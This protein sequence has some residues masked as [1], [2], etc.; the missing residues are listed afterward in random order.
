MSSRREAI[1]ELAL[2]PGPKRC[3]PNPNMRTGL[4]APLLQRDGGSAAEPLSR[5][6]RSGDGAS[7]QNCFSGSP[8]LPRFARLLR[9]G[10]SR[11]R[12]AREAFDVVES[13]DP[14]DTDPEESFP[15][16]ARGW[17]SRCA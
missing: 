4:I 8:T 2:G 3:P 15:G 6:C 11:M 14:I 12:V 7:D 1:A 9:R 17:R 5:R 13:E 16:F 10:R